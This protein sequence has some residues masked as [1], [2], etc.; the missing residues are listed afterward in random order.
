MP[1][2]LK[3]NEMIQLWRK[4]IATGV[5]PKPRKKVIKIPVKQLGIKKIVIVRKD[6][7]TMQTI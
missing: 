3:E 7:A 4:F 1:T 2:T 5:I 6:R